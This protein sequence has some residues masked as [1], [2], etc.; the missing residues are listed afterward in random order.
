MLTTGKLMEVLSKAAVKQKIIV[1]PAPE[2]LLPDTSVHIF[3]SRNS[4]DH[5]SR[6][7]MTATV[8]ICLVKNKEKE[9]KHNL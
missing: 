3:L 6:K 4:P 9:S 8:D 5:G 2:K 1:T 7:L